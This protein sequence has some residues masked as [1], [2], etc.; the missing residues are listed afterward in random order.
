V[1]LTLPL[2]SLD[3]PEGDGI[4]SS[5]PPVVD[6]HVHIFPEP[7]FE[8]IWEWFS[9]FAWP[10]RYRLHS[11]AVIEFLISRGVHHIV[12]LHY[13]HKPGIAR[14]LNEFMAGLCGRHPEITGTAAVFPG[15]TDVKE[16]LEDAFR[17]GLRGVKLHAHV[18]CFTLDSPAMHEIYEICSAHGR[19]LI[20]HVGREPRNPN[21]PY[22]VDPYLICAAEK[23]ER[24]LRD[25]PALKVCV[26]HM[27]ADEFDAY[28]R[29]VEQYDNLWL[30]TT[31]VFAGYL[32]GADAPDLARMR[33]D[34]VLYGTDFPNIP[35]AWD[36]ELKRLTGMGL[37]DDHLEMILG[38][39]AMRLFHSD[40][41]A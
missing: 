6:G 25:Y 16:I 27:G 35:Y 40:L 28:T 37:T 36:R 31:M 17:L 33:M 3:D 11:E 21:Y 38:A 18:Q 23:V 15:E 30:D 29:M 9:Q 1:D 39:N 19:P 22:P 12:A 41:G 20:M 7:M 2:P 26:P 5:F 8:A 24:V 34:R 4:P 32:P 13:A 14:L 10:V